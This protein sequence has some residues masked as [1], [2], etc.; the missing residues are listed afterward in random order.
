MSTDPNSGWSILAFF[1]QVVKTSGPKFLLLI[2]VWLFFGQIASAQTPPCG[3]IIA[4]GEWETDLWLENPIVLV[5]VTDCDLPFGEIDEWGDGERKILFT[6]EG[7]LVNNGDIFPVLDRR[8]KK[9]DFEYNFLSPNSTYGHVIF[10]HQN[11][12][13]EFVDSRSVPLTETDYRELAI[14]FGV[15]EENVEEYAAR[16]MSE[17]P[18]DGLV[19]GTPEYQ[20]FDEFDSFVYSAAEKNYPYLE[21]GTYTI[22]YHF[23]EQES[24]GDERYL[25]SRHADTFTITSIETEPTGASSVLFLP[26]IQ[27]SRLYTKDAAG[28]ENRIWEPTDNIDVLKLALTEEGTSI[29]DIRTEDIIDEAS[30]P[31]IGK[32]IYKGFINF[33]NKLVDDKIIQNWTPFAYDW[34]HD[35]FDIVENG[36]KYLDGGIK[37]PVDEVVALAEAS[38]SGKVTIIAHSNGGLLA[39]AIMLELVERDQEGLVDKIIFIGTPQLGTPKAIGTILHGYDQEALGGLIIDDGVAREVIK[40]LPGA[41]SLL[42]SERY[43]QEVSGALV[44]FDD[45]ETTASLRAVY[46]TSIDSVGELNHFMNGLEDVAGRSAV[47]VTEVNKPGKVNESMYFEAQLNHRFKLDNWVPPADT[48]VFQITGT[49]LPTLKAIEYREVTET[50]CPLNAIS[51]LLCPTLK[52]LKPHAQFT[53]YGDETVVSKSAAFKSGGDSDV[54]YFDLYEAKRGV[55]A[56]KKSHVDLTEASEVQDFLTNIIKTGSSTAISFFSKIEPN[57]TRN[58]DIEEMNSPVQISTKD[59]NGRVTGVVEEGGVLVRKEEI[60]DSSYFEFGST[61]Y[62]IIP[63]DVERTTTLLGEAFGGYTL[64]LSSL[65]VSGNQVVEHEV[66]NATSTPDMV[67]VYSK[68]IGEYSTIETDLNN[69]GLYEYESTV[70]GVLII[71]PPLY[72]Y[73]TLLDVIATLQIKKGQKEVLLVLVKQ[74]QTLRGRASENNISSKL[75]NLVL[76]VLESIVVQYQRKSIISSA[77]ADNLI[78]IIKFLKN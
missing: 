57:S 66:R 44:K 48:K 68:K 69:D 59:K 73:Q 37:N 39:K 34:R 54:N 75:E 17:D 13:Y 78:V 29:V 52:I 42:P 51:I 70:D 56:I 40:N 6:I 23:Y 21:A 77:V 18:Y 20:R 5:P 12:N 28:A 31:I 27:A 11:N 1:S 65:D 32:N 25:A 45:S 74:A 16:L 67:A 30:V 2:A 9:Y 49:G 15:A 64:T 62:L 47:A 4:P 50:V 33:M 3:D 7:S 53:A 76:K 8:T 71:P 43:M 26:G 38:L 72:T 22:V 63:S 10:R 35:V 58:Y 55:F 61:K 36:T 60:P 46:G 19:Y 14:E 24:A 41:Y